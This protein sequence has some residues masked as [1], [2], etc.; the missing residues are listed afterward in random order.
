[1]SDSSP[2]IRR[3]AHRPRRDPLRARLTLLVALA[4]LALLLTGVTLWR[5]AGMA[6][7][8]PA[9]PGADRGDPLAEELAAAR[10]T[11]SPGTPSAPATP[12]KAASSTA[13]PAASP[14]AR[15]RAHPTADTPRAEQL[16]VVVL[17]AT[18][19]TGL[20]ART[21]TRLKRLGWRVEGAANFHGRL[22]GTTVYY[23]SGYDAAA[24]ALAADLPGSTRVRQLS[25]EVSGLSSRR[26][27][28]VLTSDY[29]G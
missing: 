23:P 13:S 3:G 8:G 4:A 25:G 18:R 26:L 5:P 16:R 1:M 20:A 6:H 2:R 14:R 29:S 27:T 15:A 22:R 7:T 28:A 17:N 19:N 21:A 11:S 12:G 9:A 24:R 10:R